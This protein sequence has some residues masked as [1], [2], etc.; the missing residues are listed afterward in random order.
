MTKKEYRTYR[1]KLV[2]KQMVPQASRKH[3]KVILSKFGIKF[4]SDK[5]K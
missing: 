5:Q 2:G 1:L 4:V 3:V